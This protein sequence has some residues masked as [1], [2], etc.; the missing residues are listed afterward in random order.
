MIRPHQPPTSSFRTLTKKLGLDPQGYFSCP[1]IHIA[2]IP[3]ATQVCYW[4]SARLRPRSEFV[5]QL[6]R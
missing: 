1:P 2:T 5:R 6:E 4:P 3:G